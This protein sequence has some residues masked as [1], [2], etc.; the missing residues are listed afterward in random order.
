[1]KIL[2][3]SIK[4]IT[5]QLTPMFLNVCGHRPEKI[6]KKVDVK[7]LV[8]SFLIDHIK[9]HNNLFSHLQLIF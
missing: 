6:D 2:I 8:P 1:M 7:L 3:T 9:K 5:G 4:T